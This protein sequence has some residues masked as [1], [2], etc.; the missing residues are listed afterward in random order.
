MLVSASRR[1]ARAE[2]PVGAYNPHMSLCIVLALNL[3]VFAAAPTTGEAPAT[4][5][6]ETQPAV[7]AKDVERAIANLGDPRWSVRREAG[8]TLL[9]AGGPC[10]PAL[11]HAFRESRRHEV[12]V[13]IRGSEQDR[14]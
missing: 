7:S 14:R 9:D 3:A 1:G 13:R 10:L 11:R 12:Q 6:A 2:E 5:P 8:F 4:R